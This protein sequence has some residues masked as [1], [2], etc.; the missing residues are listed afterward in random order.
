MAPA[1]KVHMLGAYLLLLLLPHVPQCAAQQQAAA[2]HRATEGGA[3]QLP[4][5]LARRSD[6]QLDID[7]ASEQHRAGVHAGQANRQISEGETSGH[8]NRNLKQEG[9]GMGG[10]DMGMGMGMGGPMGGGG[11]AG[12]GSGAGGGGGSGGLSLAGKREKR[13]ATRPPRSE[14][15]GGAPAPLDCA[16]HAPVNARVAKDIEHIW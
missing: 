8:R 3:R 9:L 11:D 5:Q 1:S 2:L 14:A 10:D 13:R 15:G 6:L 4:E 7:V 12:A 16:A